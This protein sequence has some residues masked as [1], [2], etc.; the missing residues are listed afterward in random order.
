MGWR[1][2]LGFLLTLAGFWFFSDQL[3]KFLVLD[4][5]SYV[6]NGSANAGIWQRFL[7]GQ[8]AIASGP[9]TVFD[10]WWHL[11]YA[12]NGGG[13]FSLLA[14]LQESL[15]RPLF[16]TAGILS[17]SLLIAYYFVSDPSLRVRRW[18]LAI[19]IGGALGN[20]VDRVRLHHVIDFIVWHVG[21][22]YYWPSFNVADAAVA[23][24]AVLLILEPR[25]KVG[26][27]KSPIGN[28]TP[29]GAPA[30]TG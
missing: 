21:S 12:E 28:S 8:H 6:P 22:R 23:I 25:L 16:I 3:T 20:F 2:R 13:A 7:H 14:G 26:P 11:Q 29:G 18:G 24:G 10:S 19:V 30:Q 4:H 27:G 15:R 9:V 5:L 17:I 1:R